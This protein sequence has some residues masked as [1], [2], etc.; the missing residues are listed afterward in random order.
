MTADHKV[1]SEENEARLK[2]SLR[3]RGT[4]SFLIQ[5]YPGK[6]QDCARDDEQLARDR[7]ARSEKPGIIHTDNSLVFTPACEDMCW[8]HVKSTPYRLETNGSTENAVRR[9]K[10]GTSVLVVQSGLSEKWWEEAMHCF[11]LGET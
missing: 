10:E 11:S 7:A 3:S 2:A 8:N 4:G 9:V 5:S 1:L 6:K